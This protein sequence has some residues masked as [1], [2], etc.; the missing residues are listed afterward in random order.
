M[1]EGMAVCLITA[2]LFVL[3]GE[4]GAADDRWSIE[5]SP[6]FW[7]VSTKGKLSINNIPYPD[8]ET[9][10]GLLDNSFSNLRD[11]FE[12]SWT[13]FVTVR[14]GH[15]VAMADVAQLDIDNS[16]QFP[17]ATVTT[18]VEST[19]AMLAVGYRF[20]QE[21]EYAPVFDLFIGGRYNR[22]DAEVDAPPLGSQSRTE[23]WVDP[24]VGAT[25]TIPV[26]QR[27]SFNVMTNFGGFD[28]GS[29]LAR[30]VVT[31]LRIGLT[32]TL[33]LQ[34]GYRW[35]DV[36]YNAE[37]DDFYYDTVTHGW[38]AGMSFRL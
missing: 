22:H 35:L 26:S 18:E 33:S 7:G 19:W 36:N 9:T 37:G 29:D 10:F 21:D 3:A 23:D 27:I 8:P 28:V 12:A 5:I 15:W 17:L 11:D 14:K 4:A 38:L 30:E 2:L 31:L 24:I 34:G 1:K 16:M 6:Y 13:G 32:S 20:M 25:L